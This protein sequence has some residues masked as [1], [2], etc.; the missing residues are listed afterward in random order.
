MQ[1]KQLRRVE[2]RTAVLPVDWETCSNIM[3][4]ATLLLFVTLVESRI[5]G[6]RIGGR[7]TS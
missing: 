6:I 4:L 5:E 2:A 3:I 7:E 1:G